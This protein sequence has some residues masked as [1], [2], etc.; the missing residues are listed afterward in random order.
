MQIQCI[1]LEE[2]LEYYNFLPNCINVCLIELNGLLFLEFNCTF[3][4]VF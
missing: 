4:G 1:E 3:I 2:E